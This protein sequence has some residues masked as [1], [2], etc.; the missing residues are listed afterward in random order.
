MNSAL[1]ASI[2]SLSHRSGLL[3]FLGIF[4][5]QYLPYILL[6]V[7]LV[8]L[9]QIKGTRRRLFFFG[10]TAL[11]VILARGLL[12]EWIRF[13]YI[14]PRP[15]EA[16]QFTSLIPES[17]NSF[18]SG[19]MTFYFALAAVLFFANRKWGLWFG[20]ATL[21]VGIARIFVGV[22]WPADILGGIIIGI[23]SAAAVHFTL[24]RFGIN[25]EA[26]PSLREVIV[27][28]TIVLE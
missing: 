9:I 26:P 5:A 21:L 28:E 8:Y 11:A 7:F 20:A 2:Y 4:A 25:G 22:H 13:F 14:H 6:I 15:F 1:F 27:E 17:G 3:D 16:L 10:E 18:P 23:A 19:H 24:R 12:T